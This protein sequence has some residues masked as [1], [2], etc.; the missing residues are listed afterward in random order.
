MS[1]DDFGVQLDHV[2]IVVRDI[3]RMIAFYRDIIGLDLLRTGT[4][5]AEAVE[6]LAGAV[7]VQAKYAFLGNERSAKIEL[8]QFVPSSETR[9]P[10]EAFNTLGIRHIAFT[11]PRVSDVAERMAASACPNDLRIEEF[12]VASTGAVARR[13]LT[14]DPE[15]N[16]IE[17]VE[18]MSTAQ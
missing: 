1:R 17:F 3:D 18:Q 13:G 16:M 5:P 15:G 11:V 12:V 10:S 8:G 7:G 2:A 6:Q 4:V 14:C 9:K